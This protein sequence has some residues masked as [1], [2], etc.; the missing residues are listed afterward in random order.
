MTLS[1]D[2]AIRR[3][4][5]FA[6]PT[7][8]LAVLMVVVMIAARVVTLL[9]PLISYSGNLSIAAMTALI[10]GTGGFGLGVALATVAVGVVG[11]TRRGR[12]RGLAATGLAVGATAAVVYLLTLLSNAIVI[13]SSTNR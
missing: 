5:P 11:V 13:A 12:P 3:G 4:N 10:H 7:M 9:A 6:I 1:S 8:A 2:P